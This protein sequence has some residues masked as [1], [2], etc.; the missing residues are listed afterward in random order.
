MAERLIEILVPAEKAE[1]MRE[2][3]RH[4]GVVESRHDTSAPVHLFTVQVPAERVESVLDPIEEAFGSIEGFHAFVLSLEAA[5]PRAGDG[6]K[7]G[8]DTPGPPPNEEASRISRE[9][10]YSDLSEHARSSRVFLAMVALSTIVAAIGLAR[11]NA[12]IVIG[13][14]VM[15]PLLGPNMAL[16]LATTLGDAKLAA[17]ALRTIILGFGCAAVVALASGLLLSFDL[18]SNEIVSRTFVGATDVV[19]AL[20]AGVAGGL[21]F[22]SGVPASLVGVMVAVALLP[23]LVVC[24][25]LLARGTISASLGALLLLLCNVITINLA[26]VGTFLFQ[27]VSPRSWWDVERSKRMSR[28]ALAVW[29]MLLLIVVAL[30]ILSNLSS[31]Q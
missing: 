15:A 26:G 30:I 6:E 20:A 21:A 29:I 22:T 14:M 27:G 7:P 31:E 12:A 25:M 10:L 5:L 28:R 8:G 23:P 13:A 2:L 9:E 24:G 11:N 16:S 4:T 3:V 1:Q 19:V 18:D 17:Q